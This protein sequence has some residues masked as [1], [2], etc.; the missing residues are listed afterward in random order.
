VKRVPGSSGRLHKTEE[1]EWEWSD[2]ECSTENP[3]KED[4]HNVQNNELSREASESSNQ[5][6]EPIVRMYIES[7][8]C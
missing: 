3:H 2:E 7:Y 1:G 6:A 8:F 4:S 5:A